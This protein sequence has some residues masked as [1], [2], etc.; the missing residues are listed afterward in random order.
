MTKS[1]TRQELELQLRSL[2]PKQ[3]D[4]VSA[5]DSSLPLATAGLSGLFGGYLLGY[6][7]GRRRRKS[8]RS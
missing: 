1:T 2:L 6:V 7:K 5:S 8:K 3:A 4:D